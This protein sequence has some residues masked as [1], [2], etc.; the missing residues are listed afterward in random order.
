MKPTRL[1]ALAALAL[2]F[3]ACQ[4][5]KVAHGPH[6]FSFDPPV[7]QPTNPSA[8]KVKLSTG[9]QRLYVVEGNEVLLAT[10]VTVGKAS[11]PT[12]MG[13]F[14]IYSKQERRRRVSQPGA[15]YPMTY[16]MEFKPAYGMHW[17]F[18]KPVPATHGCVRMP[19]K[20]AQKVFGLVRNGTP[21][22]VAKSQPW[23]ESH[24]K[25]LPHLD[26]SRLPDPPDSYMMS[27]QVFA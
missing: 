21:L 13:D 7:K 8:V 6:S 24:G 11:S 9:A 25:H 10:P 4:T 22:Q 14:T 1:L 12:P 19:L 2:G 3:T 16:W 18:V 17:G 26:D 23:D 15:G 27:P 5:P 20:A